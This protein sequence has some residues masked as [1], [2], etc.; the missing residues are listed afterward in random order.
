[1]STREE[2]WNRVYR[3]RLSNEV[4]WFQPEPTRSLELITE[5]GALPDSAIVDIGGGDSTLVDALLARGFRQVTVLDVAAAALERAR[6]RLGPAAD[7]V[8]WRVADVTS[9]ELPPAAYDL[10]HDRAVFHFLVDA[11]ERRQYVNAAANALRTGGTL[12]IS[13]F[14]LDGPTRC[15][16]LDVQRYD[17]DGLAQEFGA[18]FELVKQLPHLHHTP[19]GGEQRFTFAVFRRV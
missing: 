4:S 15:S 12:I 13:T 17:A 3:T 6:A 19:S 11:E 10:W 14:A 16:G 8:T 7:S 18:R 9:A 5:A 1:M 2:H